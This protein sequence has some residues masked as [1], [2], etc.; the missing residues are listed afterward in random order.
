MIH[1]ENRSGGFS[2][3]IQVN[4]M[5]PHDNTGVPPSDAVRVIVWIPGAA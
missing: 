3:Q 2:I 5:A 4:V 1:T